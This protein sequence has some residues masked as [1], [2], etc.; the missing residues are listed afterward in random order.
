[1]ATL[2]KW[3]NK[4]TEKNI[5]P[6]GENHEPKPTTEAPK[7]IPGWQKANMELVTILEARAEQLEKALTADEL[8]A[9]TKCSQFSSNP[10]SLFV[11]HSQ[12]LQ[13]TRQLIQIL[14][15]GLTLCDKN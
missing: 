8:T 15:N 10:V 9:V 3:N 13:V 12:D 7:E 1:M 5:I 4:M 2:Q 11:N 6:L 14:G